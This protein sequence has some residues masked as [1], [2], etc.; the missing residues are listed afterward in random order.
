[1][2]FVVWLRNY[3]GQFRLTAVPMVA[4][5]YESNWGE[6]VN[7]YWSTGLPNDERIYPV[8]KKLPCHWMID[9][10]WVSN[11][12][13]TEIFD[14]DWQTPDYVTNGRKYLAS[15]CEEANKISQEQ[16]GYWD[17]SSM[18]GPLAWTL[19]KDANS[20][21]YRVG[22]WYASAH[23][24]EDANPKWNGRPWAGFDP[25]TYDVFHTDTP[26]PGYDFAA[27]GNMYKGDIIYSYSTLYASNDER[28]EHVFLVDDV[29]DQGQR[30]SITNMIQ[31]KPEWDCFIKEVVLYTPGDTVNGVINKEWNSLENGRTGV[32]GFDIFRWKWVMYHLNG[33]PVEYTARYGDTIETIAFDWKVSPQAILDANQF[34][35]NIQLTPGQIINL[36]APL[37]IT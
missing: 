28:F 2:G 14:L 13:V 6:Y 27:N 33:Q 19:I 15:N 5:V 8:M 10:G 32:M 7:A 9:E 31:N 11:E 22:S 23:I 4:G 35:Q 36:P 20:F 30:I 1:N 18:C 16:I 24:F 25:E 21:P 12:T 3:G 37:P 29:N 26:M 34:V 17:A